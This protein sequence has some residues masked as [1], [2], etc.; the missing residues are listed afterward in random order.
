MPLLLLLTLA[1]V[2]IC[3]GIHLKESL[4]VAAY[5]GARVGA[6]QGGTN[7]MAQARVIE[8][9][10]ERNIKFDPASS[11]EIIRT[12]E[13]LSE[14]FDTAETLEHCRVLVRVPTN[15]NLLLPAG[16]ITSPTIESFV[17]IRKEFQNTN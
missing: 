5:E 11:I 16:I 10:T 8:V 17:W 9:L 13:P 15:S 6:G 1:T 14:G 3:T 12:D 4:C 7:A 2:D